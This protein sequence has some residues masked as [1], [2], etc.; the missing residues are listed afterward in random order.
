MSQDVGIVAFE[1]TRPHK[2]VYFAIRLSDNGED[3]IRINE[4][5]YIGEDE[6]IRTSCIMSS[7]EQAAMYIALILCDRNY[8]V[9][10]TGRQDEF[11][12]FAKCTYLTCKDGA[13]DYNE[14]LAIAYSVL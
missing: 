14:L 8:S 1:H 13:Y 2:P 3:T 10:E 4:Y 7:P 9:V 12:R 11:G 6:P 5:T